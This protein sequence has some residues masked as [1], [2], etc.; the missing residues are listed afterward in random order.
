MQNM[1]GMEKLTFQGLPTDRSALNKLTTQHPGL[2]SH[3]SNNYQMVNRGVLSGTAQAAFPSN[4]QNLLTRQNLMNSNSSSLQHEASSSFSFNNSSQNPSSQ[5][6]GPSFHQQSTN[7]YDM[8]QQ[9]HLQPYQGNQTIKQQMMQQL[10]QDMN[11]NNNVGGMQNAMRAG[12]S[13]GSNASSGVTSVAGNG[14]GPI[15]SVSN[16]FKAG[17]N[18][19]S[20]AAGGNNGFNP[21]AY[22]VSNSFKA[23]SNSDSS[24]AGGNNGFN[25]TANQ[26]SN[27]FKAGSNSDSSAAGGNNGFNPTAPDLPQNLPLS[28]EEIDGFLNS[29]FDEN[30]G[31][32]WNE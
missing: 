27:S 25:P 22:Q 28:D 6:Q 29:D 21:T 8:L 9:S 16:S 4:F 5:F 1:H 11:R 2:N 30:L 14:G 17:S 24:T 3:I 31:F 23:A 18:S 13:Y 7:G 19:D 10:L 26:A 12:V 32:N 20:S 15:P